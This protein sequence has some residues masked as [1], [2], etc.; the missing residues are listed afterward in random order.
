MYLD[1]MIADELMLFFRM[2]GI[3]LLPIHDSFII[4]AGYELSLKSEMMIIFKR[5]MDS[6]ILVKSTGPKL[7][8]HFNKP[9]PPSNDPSEGIVRG[10]DTWDLVIKDTSNEYYSIYHNAWM[11]WRVQKNINS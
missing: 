6:Y 2:E 4:R 9:P 5:L 3:V 10:V 7:R 11:M 1:S 8:E